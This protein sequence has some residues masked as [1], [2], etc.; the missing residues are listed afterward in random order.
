MTRRLP[1][2]I[3]ELL[4]APPVAGQGVHDYIFNVAR[5]LLPYW[6]EERICA[7]GTDSP[8]RITQTHVADMFLTLK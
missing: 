3:E 6:D 1:A 8:L 2:F 4:T 5:V 7:S